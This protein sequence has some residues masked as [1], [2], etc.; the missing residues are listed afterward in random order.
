MHRKK[1]YWLAPISL[2]PPLQK[3]CL[4]KQGTRLASNK[5]CLSMTLDQNLNLAGLDGPASFAKTTLAEFQTSLLRFLRVWYAAP[6]PA[7]TSSRISENA[8]TMKP[9]CHRTTSMPVSPSASHERRAQLRDRN[10]RPTKARKCYV[11]YGYCLEVVVHSFADSAVLC[12]TPGKASLR[13]QKLLL[14]DAG[15]TGI[16]ERL[17]QAFPDKLAG[18]RPGRAGR[19]KEWGRSDVSS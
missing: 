11:A 14:R 10:D 19:V 15:R 1:N 12:S 18:C 2:V 7:W 16:L 17:K 3:R 13:H 4:I 6:K 8:S 9:A 5:G